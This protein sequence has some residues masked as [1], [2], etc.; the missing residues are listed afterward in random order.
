MA[1]GDVPV[2]G[3]AVAASGR[4]FKITAKNL[5]RD[6]ENFLMI[7]MTPGKTL[8][9]FVKADITDQNS[10]EFDED[11]DNNNWVMEISERP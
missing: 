2:E 6:R 11:V 9:V 1:N 10:P 5:V 8:H 4:H 3:S 7:R